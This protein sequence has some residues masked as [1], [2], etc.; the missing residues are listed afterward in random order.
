[1]ESSLCTADDGLR[2]D[3]AVRLVL[4]GM[5]APHVAAIDDE[6]SRSARTFGAALDERR[7]CDAHDD[8][9][10]RTTNTVPPLHD[11]AFA[12]SF[13]G[14]DIG[15]GDRGILSDDVDPRQLERH[16][17]ALHARRLDVHVVSG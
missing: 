2:Y 15:D 3:K 12:R 1:M 17:P 9:A 13:C 7:R 4:A 16:R 5:G 6:P 14:L 10:C 8:I 11:F